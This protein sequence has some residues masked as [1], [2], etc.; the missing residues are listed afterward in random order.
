MSPDMYGEL[1][2]SSAHVAIAA[3]LMIAATLKL[4]T[5]RCSIRMMILP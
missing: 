4:K 3:R 5:H 2:V 1:H